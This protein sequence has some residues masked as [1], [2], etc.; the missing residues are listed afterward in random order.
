MT[1]ALEASLSSERIEVGPV[2]VRQRDDR[3]LQ[4]CLQ[5][6]LEPLC[7][8]TGPGSSRKAPSAACCGRRRQPEHEA[9]DLLKP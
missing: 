8:G 6:L 7:D 1:D 3:P 2:R 5:G 9:A 4:V